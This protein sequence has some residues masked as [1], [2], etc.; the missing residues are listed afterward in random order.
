MSAFIDHF[1]VSGLF[2]DAMCQN[3]W[4]HGCIDPKRPEV[5]MPNKLN[6]AMGR[7]DS[8]IRMLIDRLF[9]DSCTPMKFD[10]VSTPAQWDK[11]I[12]A[13]VNFYKFWGDYFLQLEIFGQTARALLYKYAFEEK[14]CPILEKKYQDIFGTDMPLVMLDEKFLRAITEICARYSATIAGKTYE[15]FVSKVFKGDTEQM[16][17]KIFKN[18][19]EQAKAF[20]AGKKVD[21]SKTEACIDSE[22]VPQ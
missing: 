6:G 20:Q 11:M 2:T 4:K 16:F 7:Q 12:K 13:F 8:N 19:L 21:D 5:K 1:H 10:Q 15:D 18:P 3:I 9:E 22:D 17:Q 14:I